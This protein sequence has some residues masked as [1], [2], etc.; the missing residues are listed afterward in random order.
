MH[1]ILIPA[2]ADA[3]GVSPLDQI[4]PMAE[5]FV[6]K[7]VEY[8]DGMTTLAEQYAEMKSGNRQLWAVATNGN[9][10]IAAAVTMLEKFSTGLATAS[11]VLLGGEN[12]SIKDL[13]DLRVEFEL[14]AKAQGCNRVRFYARK[15]WAK[16]LPDYK[17]VSFVMSKEI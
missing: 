5:P 9:Q 15:G 2:Q 8:S 1:L 6:Q 13:I 17:L 14:W 3:N 11:I 12:G 7:A 16:Y 4:W 10:I